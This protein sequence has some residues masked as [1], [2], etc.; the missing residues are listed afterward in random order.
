MPMK[1][2]MHTAIVI[3]LLSTGSI[4]SANAQDA[5]TILKKMDAVLYAP[6]DMT[7]THRLILIDKNGKQ[8]TR[9]A[10]IMQKGT[11]KRILR[12]TAPASQAGIAVL[13]LPDD[14]MYMYLPAFGKER[15]IAGSVKNQNF[16]GTD[17]SYDDMEPIPYADK[18]TPELVKT[19]GNLFVLKLTPKGA[20]DYSKIIASVN[21]SNYYPELMEYYDKGNNKI[22][23]AKYTFE[24]K[25]KY[26]STSEIEMTDLKKSH[27]TR[28]QM[29]DVKYD[30]GLSDDEFT[31]RKLKQ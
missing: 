31:V 16:A 13:A 29:S 9:E 5:S 22:K 6:A 25:G 30:T 3:I 17:F 4:F 1:T 15:R 2:N 24:K 14:I 26:W 27:R 20:S 18:Y 28:M 19:E 23:E 7:G 12:F 21:Q 8:E 10:N 11:D